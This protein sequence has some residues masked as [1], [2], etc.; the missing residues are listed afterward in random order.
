M[1]YF[2]CPLLFIGKSVG[3]F[4][5]MR[6]HLE[7]YP[8]TAVAFHDQDPRYVAFDRYYSSKLS[9]FTEKMQTTGGVE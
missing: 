8:H 3:E 2:S 7:K 6:K 5:A 1:S 4:L 9:E